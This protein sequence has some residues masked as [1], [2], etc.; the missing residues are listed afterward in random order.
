MRE[1]L[2]SK[3]TK[4][5]FSQSKLSRIVKISQNH[6]SNIESGNRTPS[7]SIAKRIAEI[8]D[9]DWTLF[10]EDSGQ[11]KSRPA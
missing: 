11:E 2:R 7:V 8:L 1:W 10:Y 3:R 4:A 6:Y 5:N 9:F